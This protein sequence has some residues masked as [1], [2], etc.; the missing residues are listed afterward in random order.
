M[1]EI[2]LRPA[3]ETDSPA[4]R[5]LVRSSHINPTGLSWQRFLVALTPDGELIG[6]GQV[7]PHMDGSHELASIA[8]QPAYRK[9]GVARAIIEKLMAEAPRPLYLMCRSQ[10][11][12]LYEKFG[13][14]ALRPDDMPRYFRRISQLAGLVDLLAREGSTL[15]VMRCD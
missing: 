3:A 15:L 10:L 4:I 12:A 11:G 7:K 6:C 1:A 5:A 13:F 9:Q 14:Y 8:V 2:V